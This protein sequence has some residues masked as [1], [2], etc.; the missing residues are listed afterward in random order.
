MA[1]VRENT[2]RRRFEILV[3]GEVVGFVAYRP[4]PDG[5]V[6]THTEVERAHRGQGLAEEL[7]AGALDGIRASGRRLRSECPFMTKYLGEHPEYADLV[8]R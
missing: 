7:A 6:F 5:V 4:R 3:D 8:S 2:D 1:E